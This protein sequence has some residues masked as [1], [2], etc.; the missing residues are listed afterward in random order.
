M[1]DAAAPRRRLATLKPR[2][3]T[4]DARSVKRQEI[5]RQSGRELQESRKRLF[6]ENPLCAPCQRFGKVTLATER[7]HLVALADG[8]PD[9]DANTEPQ[10]HDCNAAQ[11]HRDRA[12]RYR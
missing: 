8:G 5:K 11:E 12:R 2:V 4:L 7:G 6:R 3:A 9:T 10:C 1:S